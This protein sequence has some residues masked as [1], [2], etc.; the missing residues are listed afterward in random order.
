MD[1]SSP[2]VR[3]FF[4]RY[5]RSRNTFDLGLIDSQYPD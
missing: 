1:T 4:E 2:V 5:E 3:E